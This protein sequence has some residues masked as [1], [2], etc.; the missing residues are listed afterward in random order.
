MIVSNVQLSTKF[1]HVQSQSIKA[2]F[3]IRLQEISQLVTFS[4]HWRAL[5]TCDN[6]TKYGSF[7]VKHVLICTVKFTTF[8]HFEFWY[9][10]LYVSV[11]DHTEPQTLGK[12]WNL[13]I[14][15]KF[16]KSVIGWIFRIWV[17]AKN[18]W[19]FIPLQI[20]PERYGHY[21]CKLTKFWVRKI[22]ENSGIFAFKDLYES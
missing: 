13:K 10:R 20:I 21:F 9:L 6:S 16:G 15:K 18:K 8:W 7:S 11:W 4:N 2:M 3:S 1:Y 19:I 12:D 22:G 5:L 17:L 14:R